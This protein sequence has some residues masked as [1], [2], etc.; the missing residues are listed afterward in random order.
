[1]PASRRDLRRRLFALAA[2]QGGYFTAAQAKEVGYSYQAQAHHV[3][4]GNWLRIDRGIFRL[5]EW[6]PDLHDDLA[7]WTLW[8]R[9]RGVVSH[10]TAL[11]VHEIGEFESPQVHL[12]VPAG[13][14]SRRNDAV[15]LHVSDLPAADI[16]NRP[17]FRVTTPLRSL[18]DV[19]ARG[20]D[21]DQ[22]ARA[23]TEARQRGLVSIRQLRARAEA[24][25]ARAAL[26]IER[27]LQ[28]MD[29]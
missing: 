7:R 23:I 28:R 3:G 6:V 12:T 26:Y 21:D 18:V 16:V 13:F 9:G 11:A 2:E 14:T 15:R 22:L 25:D 19:T 29:A 17:G 1:V 8:S 20:V 4:A 5:A 27:A 24:I 10:E